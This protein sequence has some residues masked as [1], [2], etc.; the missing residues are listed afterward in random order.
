MIDYSWIKIG[1]GTQ[2]PNYKLHLTDNQFLSGH[3]VPVYMQYT[4]SNTLHTTG[5]G[6]GATDGFLTGIN[7]NGVAQ[8]IQQEDTDMM[9]YTDNTKR[10]LIE[11][12][13]IIR[14]YFEP[15]L[16]VP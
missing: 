2:T 15:W 7:R 12:N 1:I 16:R 11:S 5:T 13:G 8:L 14:E 3:A 6:T 10:M 4:N 9:F